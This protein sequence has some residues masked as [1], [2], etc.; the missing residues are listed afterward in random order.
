VL[1]RGRVETSFKVVNVVASASLGQKVNLDSVLKVFPDA[2]YPSKQFPG[3]VLRLRKPRTSALIFQSGKIICTG[4]KN[5]NE[6]YEAVEN[7]VKGLIN[8]GVIATKKCEFRVNNM[9]ASVNL[10]RNVDLPSISRWQKTIYEPEQFPALIYRMEDPK[11]VLLIF[12]SGKVICLGTK[13]EN[14]IHKAIRKLIQKLNITEPFEAPY[15]EMSNMKYQ[16]SLVKEAYAYKFRLIDFATSDSRG[17]ACAYV[18]GLWC[19]NRLCVGPSCKFANILRGKLA[20]GVYGCWGFHWQEGWYTY[21]VK[22]MQRKFF[23]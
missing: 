4:G 3:I 1:E 15:L 11:V 6:A 23:D 2:R 21:E 18:D 9:V 12:S 19:R 17:K 5:E 13:N 14:E 16:E 7:I 10:G 22:K 20:N 8:K